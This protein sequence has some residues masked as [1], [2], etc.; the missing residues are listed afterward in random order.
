MSRRYAAKK[1]SRIARLYFSSLTFY[2]CH[3]LKC[4]TC[5]KPTQREDN[6]WR[7][8]CSERCQL[9]DFDKWTSEEYRVP[10]RPINAAE[11]TEPSSP[12]NAGEEDAANRLN[13][14]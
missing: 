9:I 7:P 13:R 14:E 8:F 11:I 10:G 1:R 6:P 2:F 12:E 3:V 4:P 5:G